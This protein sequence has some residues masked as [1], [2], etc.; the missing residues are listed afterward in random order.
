MALDHSRLGLESKS[1]RFFLR[2]TSLLY[3]I[4]L[5][6]LGACKPTFY[7]FYTSHLRWNSTF[8]HTDLGQNEVF[9]NFS[10]LII[11][12]KKLL[13]SDWLRKECSFS[14]TR[15]QITNGFWLAEN[16]KETTK[17]QS[18]KSCFN[19]KIEENGHGFEQT[20]TGFNF[21]DKTT[22]EKLKKYSKN[23]NTVEKYL[24][25]A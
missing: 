4:L 22:I 23:P 18:D 16:T 3:K 20:T 12:T 10:R 17:N 11:Y 15:V 7:T 8:Y 24:F 25:L 1:G 13:N 5:T 9:H 6:N 2:L 19:N 21:V 14:V